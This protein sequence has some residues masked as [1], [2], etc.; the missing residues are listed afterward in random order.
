MWSW[1]FDMW[2]ERD[3]RKWRTALIKQWSVSDQTSEATTQNVIR[4]AGWFTD[5]SGRGADKHMH[6]SQNQGFA[7]WHFDFWPQSWCPLKNMEAQ[8]QTHNFRTHMYTRTLWELE[9]W[10]LKGMQPPLTSGCI[11]ACVVTHTDSNTFSQG[12]RERAFTTWHIPMSSSGL[13]SIGAEFKH[14]TTLIWTSTCNP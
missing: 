9:T 4:W 13:R 8:F 12:L 7:L 2:E 10:A 6:T 14:Q 3:F 1:R 5:E 11:K